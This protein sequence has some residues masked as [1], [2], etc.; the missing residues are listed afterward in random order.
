MKTKASGIAHQYWRIAE[1]MDD[2]D[3]E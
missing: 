3:D 1:L 2:E